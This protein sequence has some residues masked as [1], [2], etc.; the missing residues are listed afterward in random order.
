MSAGS[1]L[2][3][4]GRRPGPGQAAR[5]RARGRQR[6]APLGFPGGAP[7]L[8]SSAAPGE[9]PAASCAGL[10]HRHRIKARRIVMS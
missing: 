6:A 8:R 3:G 2:C 4:T 1:V 5:P 9:R 10:R 7:A